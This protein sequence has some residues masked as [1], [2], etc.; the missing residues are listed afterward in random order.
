MALEE[1]TQSPVL[2]VPLEWVCRGKLVISLS[3]E[4]KHRMGSEDPRE[5]CTPEPGQADHVTRPDLGYRSKGLPK[6]PGASSCPPVRSYLF[7]VEAVEFG[8]C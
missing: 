2:P 7:S 1:A 4:P 5:L 3:V 6:A 8:V